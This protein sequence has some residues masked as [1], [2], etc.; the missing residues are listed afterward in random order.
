MA[1]HLS[2]EQI[3]RYGA[4]G[5]TFRELI[6]LEGH[7]AECSDCREQ[8]VQTCNP[9]SAIYRKPGSD[10]GRHLTYDQLEAY[11]D[12]RLS[13]PEC[14]MAD[15]HLSSCRMCAAEIRD[16]ER[17]K[18]DLAGSGEKI[19]R[20]PIMWL[21]AAPIG[22]AAAIL[23]A[24]AVLWP[25]T[26]T[27][28]K[29]NAPQAV[30]KSRPSDSR[31]SADLTGLNME[32]QSAVRHSLETKSVDIP[33]TVLELAGKRETLLGGRQRN[34]ARQ[35]LE[36]AGEAVLEDQPIFRWTEMAGAKRYSIAIYD[37]NFSL[38]ARSPD[39]HATEWK[40]DRPLERGTVYVWQLAA[41]TENGGTVVAPGK[42]EPEARFEV[43]SEKRAGEI[44]GY[45]KAYPS[46]HLALAI[47]YAREG[48]LSEGLRE[49]E[50]IPPYSPDS[51]T[52]QMLRAQIERARSLR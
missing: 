38:I 24:I 41:H 2:Q 52:A 13:G 29:E 9:A 10:D 22:V 17:F 31:L 32:D 6:Q 50:Q 46:A 14:R 7:I 30:E 18:M 23:I 37:T 5:V 25:G 27:P 4:G 34:S 49:L 12:G 26:P 39:L 51:E 21:G 20:V 42:G 45:A 43:L 35:I 16:L 1:G 11:I 36:P 15:A 44:E 40:V 28:R 48:A 3:A 8:L 33:A 19:K 47:L